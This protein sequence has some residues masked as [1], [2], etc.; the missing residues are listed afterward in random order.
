MQLAALVL[1]L[2]AHPG[3]RA[4]QRLELGG[5][6]LEAER[7]GFE[8]ASLRARASGRVH[9]VRTAPEGAI[10]FEARGEQ[11]VVELGWCE[12]AEPRLLPRSVA[13]AGPDGIQ[14]RLVPELLLPQRG[15]P[16][17]AAAPPPLELRAAALALRIVPA[18]EARGRLR[19]RLL[20]LELGGQ[21]ER[22]VRL[23][24][25]ARVPLAARLGLVRSGAPGTGPLALGD[26][27]EWLET[28]RARLD[29]AAG[30]AELTGGVRGRLGL[31]LPQ[32]LREPVAD[33]QEPAAG[34]SAAAGGAWAPYE[35]EG[36]QLE[37]D[38][39]EAEGAGRRPVLQALV[40][41]GRPLRVRGQREGL[42]AARLQYQERTRTLELCGP[43]LEV[44]G[45]GGRRRYQ[46]AAA[47][48]VVLPPP[49]D[50]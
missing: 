21:A 16:A 14:L 33:P 27:P 15:Q 42:Q 10:A 44:F 26:E 48:R 25:P 9:A 35:V 39:V 40:A 34:E 20:E 7:I 50:E 19:A 29:R 47:V 6:R 41:S 8:G 22:G 43:P 1:E 28:A 18:R 38:F 3:S 46:P 5:D 36:E 2:A 31:V 32:A 24:N 11:A 12:G 17:R 37:L 13:L 23:D 30:R 49:G 4:L 45:A